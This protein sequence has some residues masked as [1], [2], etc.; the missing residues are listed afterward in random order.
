MSPEFGPI[1]KGEAPSRAVTI[2]LKTKP[3]L[4]AVAGKDKSILPVPGGVPATVETL[5]IVSVSAKL[6]A[7]VGGPGVAPAFA[8]ISSSY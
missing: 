4:F 3:S 8:R 6:N 5:K 7:G 2:N 1:V